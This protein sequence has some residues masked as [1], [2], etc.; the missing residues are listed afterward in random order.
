MTELKCCV[1]WPEA[2][3][4]QRF[5]V[6]GI[7]PAIAYVQ[8]LGIEGAAANTWPLL[9]LGRWYFSRRLGEC[10]RQF[11]RWIEVAI[12]DGCNCI[13][14]LLTGIPRFDD[15]GDI[16]AWYPEIGKAQV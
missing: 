2:E 16:E 6:G 10:Q 4:K 1:G 5:S 3:W 11:C 13:T 9:F 12:D 8:T 14:I 7:I 15:A